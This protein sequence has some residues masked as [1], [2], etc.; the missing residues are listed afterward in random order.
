M[1]RKL[2]LGAIASA[3]LMTSILSA[4]AQTAMKFALDWKFEG[5]SAPYFVALDKGYY[6]AEGLD[7]TIDSGPGS[8]AGIARVAAGTYPIGFFDINS[9]AR[10]RDQNPDKDVKSVMMVYDRP[11]FAIVSTTKSNI[12][13]PKDLEG[14]V[15][16]APAA[17][18][19]FAQWKIF[20][21]ENKIDDSK[22]KIENVGFPVREP[23]LADGKVDAITGFAYS[24]YFN[25]LSRGLDEKDI[26]VML[27]SDHGIVLYGNALMVNPEFAKANPKAV[28]GFVRAT[29]K[30]I[31]D[32]YKDPEAA[33]KSVMKRNETADEKIELARLK[34]SLKDNF[35]T[36]WVKTN[37]I[38]DI[39]SKRMSDAIDQIAITYEFKNA[40]PKPAD[41]FTADYLPPLDQRKF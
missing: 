13:T 20:V 16:G 40:R 21:K 23:M 38:G 30:G 35:V 2:G 9:L 27:M 34:M 14:K 10:F 33:I 41:L 12:N 28:A 8:V 11:A 6:K 5:T 4:N 1:L 15:L 29:I 3:A 32:S 22:V 37:G 31:A 18:G 19:A 7:V 39:D 24:S 36:P 25:M 17:D 26:K